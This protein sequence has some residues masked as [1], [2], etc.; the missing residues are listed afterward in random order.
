MCV[1]GDFFYYAFEMSGHVGALWFQNV[2]L[3]FF[4][5]FI[6]TFRSCT[7]LVNKSILPTQRGGNGQNSA[8]IAA[9][10]STILYVIDWCF[11]LL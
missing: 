5:N 8:C 11:F 4:E 3:S 7:K 10:R 9:T 6:D 1:L 2:S